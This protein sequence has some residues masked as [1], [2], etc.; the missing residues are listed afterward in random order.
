M[1]NL[2]D[3]WTSEYEEAA[4]AGVAD[5]IKERAMRMISPGQATYEEAA[6]YIFDGTA[7]GRVA[8]EE[9]TDN[10]RTT[11][12]RI[13]D[14]AINAHFESAES[15]RPLLPIA[16][17]MDPAELERFRAQLPPKIRKGWPS[18]Y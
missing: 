15:P 1:K 12:E 8:W 4:L 2:P 11:W 16:R 14:A 10:A 7:R 3:W 5:G 18:A 13:A 9:L 17:D 6:T